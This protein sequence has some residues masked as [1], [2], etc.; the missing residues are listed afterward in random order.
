MGKQQTGKPVRMCVVCR[1]HVPRE[2]LIR[3]VREQDGRICI[4]TTGYKA[5]GRGA[6]VCRSSQCVQTAAARHS[7][8]RSF[9]RQVDRSVYDQLL[10]MVTAFENNVGNNIDT[11]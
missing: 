4:D 2:N 8:E 5:P 3:V 10:A 6:Y 1:Q 9:R 7:F 11:E